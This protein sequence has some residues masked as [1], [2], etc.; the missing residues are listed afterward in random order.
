MISMPCKFQGYIKSLNGC[1]PSQNS[2]TCLGQL[3]DP[4]MLWEYT[5]TIIEP[6]L[7]RPYNILPFL[8]GPISEPK[9]STLSSVM[10]L[11]DAVAC[12]LLL[13]LIELKEVLK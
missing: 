7:I 10:I 2:A 11:T 8:Q 4:S 13:Y 9:L 12:L 1:K 3:A 6:K 5:L